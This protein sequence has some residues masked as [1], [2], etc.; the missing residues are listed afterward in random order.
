MPAFSFILTLLL[1]TSAAPERFHVAGGTYVGRAGIEVLRLPAG[2]PLLYV[3]ARVND[4]S[5]PIGENDYWYALRHDPRSGEYRPFLISSDK[6][7]GDL[8]GIDLGKMFGDALPELVIAESDGHVAVHHPLTGALLHDFESVNN[9]RSL[10]LAD[11]DGDGRDEIYL[12]S[13]GLFDAG[14]H[15]YSPN[16]TPLWSSSLPRGAE[17]L[18]AQVDRDAALE[19]LTDSGQVFDLNSRVMQWN[20]TA[21]SVE[22]MD[23]ADFDGD[24][25]DEIV[26]VRASGEISAYDADLRALKWTIHQIFNRDATAV[27][28][29]DLEGDGRWEVLLGA[30][31][32]SSTQHPNAL[33]CYDTVTQALLFTYRTS[34]LLPERLV[35][36]D[37]DDDGRREILMGGRYAFGVVGVAAGQPSEEWRA[38]ETLAPMLGPQLGDISGDGVPELVYGCGDTYLPYENSGG[39]FML[40]DPSDFTTIAV[41]EQMRTSQG[42]DSVLTDFKL[43]D[44]DGDGVLEILTVANAL[45]FGEARVYRYAP[46]T[47]EIYL[48]WISGYPWVDHRAMT[49]VAAGDLNLDG[50]LEI[51]AGEGGRRNVRGPVVRIF[52]YGNGQQVGETRSMGGTLDEVRELDVAQVDGDPWPEVLAWVPGLGLFVFDHRSPVEEYA[53]YGDFTAYRLAQS[54]RGT[55]LFFGDAQGAVL[56]TRATPAGFEPL[57]HWSVLADPVSAISIA[58]NDRLWVAHEGRLSLFDP[59]IAQVLWT[60]EHYGPGFGDHV[61][62]SPPAPSLFFTA[63]PYALFGFRAR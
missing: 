36:V 5:Y 44:V 18:I 62:T 33:D 24:G 12:L 28:L 11:G 14:L 29:A 58:A 13:G 57:V 2:P 42:I 37:A 17:L 63:G 46:W 6:P 15:V 48:D 60:S 47:R 27:K 4:E 35:V 43:Y 10:E 9:L 52:S 45:N 41:S 1:Q 23:A 55:F 31:Q 19:A 51:L 53:I 26:D 38:A 21:T 30:Q 54:A 49:S 25:M 32:F 56:A 22:G 16:G 59:H 39:R 8:V 7:G 3:S 40:V 61:T 34:L 20:W 50:H